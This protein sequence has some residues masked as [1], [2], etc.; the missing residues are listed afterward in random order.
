LHHD[1]GGAT[2]APWC[3]DGAVAST[4]AGYA[5]LA[6]GEWGLM[7]D[8]RGWLSVIC[9]NPINAAQ[10]LGVAGGEVV[11]LSPDRGQSG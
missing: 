6:S 3:A 7:I 8:P 9:G 10:S 2:L 1:R 4:V 11:W 5:D